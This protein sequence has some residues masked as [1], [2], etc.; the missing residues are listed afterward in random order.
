MTNPSG[1]DDQ[2]AIPSENAPANPSPVDSA[3]T[4]TSNSE[5]AER[6]AFFAARGPIG[7]YR[8]VRKLGEGGMGQVWLAEQTAPLQRLVALKLIRAGVSNQVL[9]ERFESERQVLARMNHPAI[10]KVFDAGTTADGKVTIK[11]H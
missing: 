3:D 5:S 6:D 9:L 8:L 11:L 10:A 1:S 7:P 4:L 2:N